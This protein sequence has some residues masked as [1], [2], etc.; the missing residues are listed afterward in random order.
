MR[1]WKCWVC[2]N[3]SGREA[4]GL[5]SRLLHWYFEFKSCFVVR[6]EGIKEE[7]KAKDQMELVRR[8]IRVRAVAEEVVIDNMI[9]T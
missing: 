1:L 7:L 9:N 2:D 6:Q 3:S 5:L 8:M 4:N